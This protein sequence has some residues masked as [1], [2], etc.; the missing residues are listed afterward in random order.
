MHRT[1]A[2]AIL[3]LSLS[4]CTAGDL[5][6]LEK[7]QV[8]LQL[9]SAPPG[10]EAK[11]STGGTCN[12]P[13]TVPVD[14]SAGQLTVTYT[15]E[16]YQPQ[17]V[18]VQVVQSVDPAEAARASPNPVSVALEAAPKP[19]PRRRPAKKRSAP[20]KPA[21]KSA[22][23]AARPAPAPAAAPAPEP[24]PAPAPTAAPAPAPAEPAPATSQPSPWP[25]PAPPPAQSAP[26]P[27][28]PG[29]PPA[30]R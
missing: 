29:Q 27:A 20:K 2:F 8:T 1:V 21:A 10:A 19:P 22:P 9:E 23:A 15:L 4:A 11:V 28:A 16:G 5:R 26:W 14:A 6:R 18:A 12:T 24:S 13:C 7:P 3:G 30:Q 17:E 25:A